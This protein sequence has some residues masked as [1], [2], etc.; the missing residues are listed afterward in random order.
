MLIQLTQK[1][2]T[3]NTTSGSHKKIDNAMIKKKQ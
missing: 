2:E 1:H 3:D